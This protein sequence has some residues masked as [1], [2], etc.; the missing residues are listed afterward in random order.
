MKE[1]VINKLPDDPG[2]GL[3]DWFEKM[4]P[5]VRDHTRR[6]VEFKR[7]HWPGLADGRLVQRPNR[8]YPH[9]LPDGNR[10]KTFIDPSVNDYM[11]K[12]DIAYHTASLNL[13]SSQACC[14]NFL[15]P[16]RQDAQPAR[17]VLKGWFPG[18]SE[19]RGIEFE[20]TGPIEATV[21][22]GEPPGGKRGLNRTS[23]DAAIWWTA[24]DGAPR[25]TLVEW[26]Y[27]EKDFGPCGGY[28]LGPRYQRDVCNSLDVR[29]VEPARD[30]YVSNNKDP[31]TSRHYWQR[32]KDARI[33]P[34]VFKKEGCPFRGPLYQLL[35][36]QLLAHWLETNTE[37]TVD[38][39]VACFKG[40]Q[41]L[42]R[43]RTYLKHLDRYLPSAWRV[44]LAEPERFQ[45]LYVEDLMAHCDYLSNVAT[46]PWRE[47]LRERYGV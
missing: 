22:L 43:S 33:H 37:D 11:A 15:Y 35:R 42:M 40:N 25:L 28:K 17:T 38:V 5:F 23:A 18:L 3:T 1:T 12:N 45:V 34:E 13:R 41:D 8:I 32:M 44:F 46:S 39:A 2:V 47:Y 9:I 31:R 14:L 36:L 29:W 21:W 26:K 24:S 7:R 20:Y 6:Q 19:V 27:T 16:L 4:T 30:C 10:D